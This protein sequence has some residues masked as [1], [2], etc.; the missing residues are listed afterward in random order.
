MQNRM[1]THPLTSQQIESLL[2]KTQI[3]SLATLNTNNT[4]YVTPIHF[5][6]QNKTIY[7][8]GL[9]KGQKID[10]IRANP[11]VSMTVYQMQ[12]LLLPENKQP[13]ETN[14]KYQS[15]I[16]TGTASLITDSQ[17]KNNILTAIVQKYTPELTNNPLPDNMINGTAVIKIEILKI[18]GKYYD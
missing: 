18:T 3:G 13:C 17:Q 5:I 1:K 14:T 2:E 6:Y 11:N 10:N 16:I 12:D 4:P 8:H 15:V 9:P 7:F